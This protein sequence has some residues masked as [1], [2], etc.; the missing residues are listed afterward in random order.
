ML[1]AWLS[2]PTWLYIS[3]HSLT[4]SFGKCFMCKWVL[5]ATIHLKWN[6]VHSSPP[7]HTTPNH[8]EWEKIVNAPFIHIVQWMSS[9]ILNAR[10][11]FIEP[12]R[13]RFFP[14]HSFF[15]RCFFSGS[16][17]V[18]FCA[19]LFI[20]T[21]AF[22]AVYLALR[23]FCL[24]RTSNEKWWSSWIQENKKRTNVWAEK[25]LQIYSWFAEH[26]RDREMCKVLEYTFI[27]TY[28]IESNGYHAIMSSDSWREFFNVII[29]VQCDSQIN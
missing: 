14:L 28:R 20:V 11:I 2:Q 24:P 21:S 12:K 27:S 13:Q 9:F 29:R 4:L 7:H 17:L 5:Y 22:V 25:K 19:F 8:P 3:L 15:F 6:V 18:N 23:C 26:K 16:I 1:A 10:Y